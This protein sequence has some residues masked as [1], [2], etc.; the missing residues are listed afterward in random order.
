MTAIT[1]CGTP[2][3]W[4]EV[5]IT[6]GSPPNWDFQSAWLST[7]N[8]PRAASAA[9]KWRP[10]SGR[11]PRSGSSSG[12]ALTVSSRR[13]SSAPT[14]FAA[15]AQYAPMPENEVVIAFQSR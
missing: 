7:A 11:T 13:G 3:S 10:S 14:R 8:C 1:V 6:P 9:V 15:R 12:V 4:T 2:S 5:P